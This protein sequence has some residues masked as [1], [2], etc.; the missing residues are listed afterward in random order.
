MTDQIKKVAVVGFSIMGPQIAQVL[1]QAGYP[2]TV[3]ARSQERLDRGV[4]T[5]KGFMDRNVERERMTAEE[6]D[7]TMALIKSTTSLEQAVGDADLVIEAVT[8]DAEVK[9]GV[10]AQLDKAAPAHTILAS[11]T[12]SIP[13]ITMASQTER[14]DKVVG[15]H[16]FNPAP[17]MRAVEVIQCVTSSSETVDAMKAFGDS[18]G[19]TTMVCTDSPGFLVNRLLWPYLLDAIRLYESGVASKEDIDNGMM[20]GCNHPMGPL[21][22]CD[23]IGLDVIM[24]GANTLHQ[25]LGEARFAPP[26]LL[27]RMVT[28]GLLGR[29]TRKGFYDYE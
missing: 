19:K 1:I 22:L 20:M 25:E 14:P 8:E 15:L 3:T 27:R 13:I 29:K 10:F 28:A 6:R 9:K 7:A 24:R 26:P 2:T 5:I 21:T 11:N 17:V 4:A 18:L 23:L 16:F 12:S